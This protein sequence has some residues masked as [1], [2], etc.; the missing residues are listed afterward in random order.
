[1]YLIGFDK[2][3]EHQLGSDWTRITKYKSLRKQQEE[4]NR[5]KQGGITYVYGLADHLYNQHV[6]ELGKEEFCKFIA[7]NGILY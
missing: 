6:C 3:R 7:Q 4:A 1:M 2:D 5:M